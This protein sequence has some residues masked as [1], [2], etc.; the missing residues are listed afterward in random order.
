MGTG[1]LKA[2]SCIIVQQYRRD[3]PDPTAAAI[4]FDYCRARS[5]NFRMRWATNGFALEQLEAA[6]PLG[7][8]WPAPSSYV[9]RETGFLRARGREHYAQMGLSR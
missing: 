2:N 5:E 8:G 9:G 1:F 6:C 4:A 3:A 7:R